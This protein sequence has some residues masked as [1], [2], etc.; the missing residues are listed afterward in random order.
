M[1][2]LAVSVASEAVIGW[3]CD[4]LAVYNVAVMSLAIYYLAVM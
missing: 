2:G 4:W 1:I 3:W